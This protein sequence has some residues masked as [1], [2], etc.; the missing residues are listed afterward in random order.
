M[1][2]GMPHLLFRNAWTRSHFPI[3]ERPG[4]FLLLASS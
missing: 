1:A 2:L 3:F 4:M